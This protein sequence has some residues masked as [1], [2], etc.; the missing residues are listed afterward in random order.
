MQTENVRLVRLPKRK[1][2]TLEQQLADIVSKL[3]QRDGPVAAYHTVALLAEAMRKEIAL[4]LR[5]D[6]GG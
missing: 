1:I 3:R 6:W 5:G 2:R 4:P